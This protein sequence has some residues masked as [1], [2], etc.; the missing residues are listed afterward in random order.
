MS[1]GLEI[2]SYSWLPLVIDILRHWK[3]VENS[4][5]TVLWVDPHKGEAWLVE[6]RGLGAAQ[7]WQRSEDQLLVN[8]G[9]S[10]AD[11]TAVQVGVRGLQVEWRLD[12]AGEDAASKTGSVAFPRAIR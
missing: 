10:A 6:T 11:G 3:V 4:G 1:K 5:T 12:G 8:A 9:G 7:A 2:V